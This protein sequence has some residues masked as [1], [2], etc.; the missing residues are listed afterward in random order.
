MEREKS[1]RLIDNKSIVEEQKKIGHLK[2]QKNNI[3][4][5]SLKKMIEEFGIEEV[6]PE[7][8][9]KNKLL[10]FLLRRGY[11]DEDY[12]NYI[13]YF[14]GNSI[15]K[16]DMNFI[17]AVKNMEQKSFDYKL[18]K[19]QWLFNGCKYMSLAKK[20]FIILTFWSACCP[21]MMKKKN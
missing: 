13:N 19:P 1:I 2:L 3:S 10:V 20:Q 18:T 15:T 6:L 7:E 5:W 14:K 11:I 4:G 17:L 9:K 16:D 12:A 8:V 21:V